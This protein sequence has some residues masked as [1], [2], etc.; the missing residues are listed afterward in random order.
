M[1]EAVEI[2]QVLACEKQRI[3][4]LIDK[5][6]PSLTAMLDESLVHVHTTG[7]TENYASYLA[8]VSDNLEF[9]KIVRGDLNVRIFGNTAVMTGPLDQ[10]LR[11]VATDKEMELASIAT[12]VWIKSGERWKLASFH[13]CPRA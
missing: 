1:N 3:K 6:I 8:G 4:A 5:D 2:G 9:F 13:A 10:H 11:V 12:Q 7:R